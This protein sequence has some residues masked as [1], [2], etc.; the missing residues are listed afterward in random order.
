MK[1]SGKIGTIRDHLAGGFVG[2]IIGYSLNILNDNFVNGAVILSVGIVTF[3]ILYEFMLSIPP[4]WLINKVNKIKKTKKVKIFYELVSF[5]KKEK[6]LLIELIGFSLAIFAIWFALP[7]Q[8][9]VSY[10]LNETEQSLF[11][12]IRNKEPFLKETGTI[13]LYRL[14]IT[15]SKPHIQ[16]DSLLP[17]QKHENL[18]LRVNF[19]EVE[20]NMTESRNE[21]FGYT[22]CLLN[23]TEYYFLTEATSISFKVS[24]DNCPPQGYFTRIPPYEKGPPQKIKIP[25]S[26]DTNTK[27]C[28]Y[29]VPTYS[30][31]ELKLEDVKEK[32]IP[33]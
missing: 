19:G 8:L 10:T 1:I 15:D 32:I 9:E 20:I 4:G 13:N 7:T 33:K 25:F 16:L 17:N 29:I 30:W 28:S 2:G 22:Q 18:R 21:T 26:Y 24:C 12:N 14:D 6:H 3:F 31:L 5:V 27:T 11:L 23:R